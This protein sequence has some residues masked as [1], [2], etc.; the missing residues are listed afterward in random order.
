MKRRISSKMNFYRRYR[1]KFSGGWNKS[2]VPRALFRGSSDR[3]LKFTDKRS[4]SMET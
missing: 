3:P 1:G 2:D 4:S